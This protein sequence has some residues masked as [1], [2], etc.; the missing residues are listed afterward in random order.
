MLST[1]REGAGGTGWADRLYPR[2]LLIGTSKYCCLTA[3]LASPGINGEICSV[4]TQEGWNYGNVQ[5]LL[6]EKM[7]FLS[8]LYEFSVVCRIV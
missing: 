3:C 4:Q 7:L 5:L 8:D 2:P 6:E 1:D